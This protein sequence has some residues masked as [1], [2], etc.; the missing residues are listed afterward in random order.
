MKYKRGVVISVLIPTKNRGVSITETLDS[1][2]K[3][4]FKKFELVVVDGG[5]VDDTEKIV[6]QYDKFFPV[7]FYVQA[8]GLVHQ[9]N[10]AWQKA[11][12][13]YV[14]RTD[15]DAI[16]DIN[17]LREVVATFEMD[18][19]IGGVTGPS[20]VPAARQKSRDLFFY[21]NKL[22]KG[23]FF[24]RLIGKIYYDYFMEGEPT[25]VSHWFK[26]GAFAIGSNYKACLRY[27][28]SFEVDDLQACNWAA[29]KSLMNKIGGYDP[30]YLG[31]GEYHEPDAAQKIMKLGYKL[32]FNPKAI[33]YH[34]PSKEGFFKER[35]N[36]FGRALNFVNF[37]FRHIKP[38]TLDKQIRF[39]SYLVFINL[40]W[41]YKGITMKQFNQLGSIFGSV[42]GIWINTIGAKS[43]DD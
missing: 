42:K 32:Y 25:R 38:D 11:N 41:I 7:Q 9:M 13:R 3:Q 4:T 18:K 34:K 5:S 27:D 17:W 40:F 29:K 37:Y 12:G 23:N 6:K 1:L 10:V 21:Q 2:K 43:L 26:S 19:K 24:W 39:I 20:L 28:T 15:D 22:K 31:I 8:G 30:I 14:V 33:V 16:F 35:P 36:A